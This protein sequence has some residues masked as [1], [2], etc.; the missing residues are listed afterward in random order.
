MDAD[1]QKE[2]EYNKKGKIKNK[3]RERGV[4][5]TWLDIKTNNVVFAVEKDKSYS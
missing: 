1:H 2:E 5:F 4:I 3:I